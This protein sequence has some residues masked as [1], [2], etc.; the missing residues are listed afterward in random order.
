MTPRNIQIAQARVQT[1]LAQLTDALSVLAKTSTSDAL[2]ALLVDSVVKRFEVC[3]EYTW[4]FLKRAAEY[5]GT[6]A[7]GP[8][9]AIQ[10]AMQLGWITTAPDF[11]QQ[12]TDARNSAVHDYLG[13]TQHEYLALIER[14]AQEMPS[15]IVRVTQK[16]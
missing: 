10:A 2:H 13:I 4:K 16:L 11:W 15:L 12:I 1:T 14:F 9:F 8:R 5:I 6:E 3:F 7:N